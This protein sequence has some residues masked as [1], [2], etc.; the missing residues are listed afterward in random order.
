MSQQTDNI[1]DTPLIRRLSQTERRF[2]ELQDSLNDPVVLANS[3]RLVAASKEA[4]QLE[5]VVSRFREFKQAVQQVAELSEMSANKADA[6]MAELASSELSCSSRVSKT[7]WP[8]SALTVA[9]ISTLCA[10]FTLS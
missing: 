7:V 6:E 5:P 3:T 4:G 1:M 9:V 2:A 10:C 8:P